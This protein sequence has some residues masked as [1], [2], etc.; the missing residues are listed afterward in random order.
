MRLSHLTAVGP[1]HSSSH[2][3]A[4]ARTAIPRRR[5]CCRPLV[6]SGDL[7]SRRRSWRARTWIERTER[8]PSTRRRRGRAPRGS[9]RRAAE[10]APQ[11][12]EVRDLRPG[13]VEVV[14]RGRP[15]A[16]RRLGRG[17]RGPRPVIWSPA[18][19][20]WGAVAQ[21]AP[22]RQGDAADG[23]RLHVVH[24]HAARDRHARPMAEALGWPERA[25]RLRR[26][27]RAVPGPEGWAAFGHPEWGPFRLGKTNPN[28]STSGLSALIAQAY[29]ATGKTA[30]PVHR[31]PRQARPPTTSPAASSRPSST[32]AT[33]R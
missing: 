9:P 4:T 22:R 1:R 13:A 10:D 31:G 29:A 15:A 18:A 6:V 12:G 8:P 17:G 25:D 24:A 11:D 5:G 20:T 23:R 2:E 3:S 14:R 26:H 32:T 27:P 21:P 16:R 28:F 19:T 7:V 30:G 33:P